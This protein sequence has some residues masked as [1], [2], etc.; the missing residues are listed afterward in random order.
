MVYVNPEAAKTIAEFALARSSFRHKV[1]HAFRHEGRAVALVKTEIDPSF[2]WQGQ[3]TRNPIP[4]DRTILYETHVRGY[5][6]NHPKVSEAHRG[7]YK[8]M[9]APDVLGY[10]KSLGVQET[11]IF[12]SEHV[13]GVTGRS[14][15]MFELV[16]GARP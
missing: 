2:D 7:T 16:A 12:A 11:Q 4:W 6:K 14:F 9:M 8:G 5:T 3:P 13:Y 10:I 15:L 1:H